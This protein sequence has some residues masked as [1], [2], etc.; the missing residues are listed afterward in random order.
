MREYVESAGA[1]GLTTL[2]VSDHAPAYWVT[3]VDHAYPQ[4]Q[5]AVSA[6]P[7]YVAEARELQ[8]EYVGRIA[9]RVGIEADFIP[10]AVPELA[11]LLAASR[12]DYVLG[13]VHYVRGRSVFDRAR[14]REEPAEP[15][16]REY[17]RLVIAA[18]QTGLFDILA[19]LSVVEAY[20]PPMPPDLADEL[21]PEVAA[22]VAQSG[23]AVE[24]NTSGYRKMGGD[25]PFPNRRVLRELARHG[26]PLTFG[27]DS[28]APD[29]V[30]WG[31]DRV[32]KLLAEAGVSVAEPVQIATGRE[33]IWAYR[34]A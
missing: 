30:G 19:H 24:I 34:T 27:S 2:G 33:P 16:F 21:Y 4:T 6:L 17:Y 9:V 15:V 8:T 5:M 31:R 7:G 13:S 29:L 14:W 25:E 26:V 28:H 20:A 11:T 22:A 18:A 3:G 1:H 10:E 32:E 12:F 23:C